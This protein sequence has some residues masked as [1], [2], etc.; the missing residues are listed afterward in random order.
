MPEVKVEPQEVLLPCP[1]CGSTHVEQVNCT[2]IGAVSVNC[3]DEDCCLEGPWVQYD[4]GHS[5][6]VPSL[7]E[8]INLTL[9][10]WNARN[11]SGHTDEQLSELAEQVVTEMQRRVV[12]MRVPEISD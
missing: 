5:N 7:Q 3:Q 1:C 11:L 12:A 8:A 6:G 4:E 9:K 2:D 10:R